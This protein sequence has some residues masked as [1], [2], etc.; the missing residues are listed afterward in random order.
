M[1]LFNLSRWRPAHLLLAWTT[2]WLALLIVA[3]GPAIPAMLRATAK[4]V[5]GEINASFGNSVFVLTVK[6]AGQV[7]WTGSIHALAAALTPRR[8]LQLRRRVTAHKSPV[9]R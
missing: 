4:D 5:H 3:I 9:R 7:T 1:S 8:R 2:Y 6:Q